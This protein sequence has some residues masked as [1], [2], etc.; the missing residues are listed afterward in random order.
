MWRGWPRA[1][2]TVIN[3]ARLRPHH[4]RPASAPPADRPRRG[5]GQRRL[6]H[7]GRGHRQRADR[8]GRAEALRSRRPRPIPKAASAL[9]R[10]MTERHRHGRR[11]PSSATGKLAGVADRLYRSRPQLGGLHHS[12]LIILA[13]RPSWARPRSPPTSPSTPP[14]PTARS[15][16]KR[17]TATSRRRGRRLL[18]ARNVGRAARHP[19]PRR[20]GADRRR[21]RSAAAR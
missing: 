9:Q 15:S 7:D 12:D 17:A 16:T 1:A 14:R 18:L 4:L 19:H 11:P 10:A 5:H 21:T 3:A 2:V 8:A 13:G 20:A 6:R